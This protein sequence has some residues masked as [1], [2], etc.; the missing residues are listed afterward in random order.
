MSAF[1]DKFY[2]LSVKILDIRDYF[3]QLP[4][5]KQRGNSDE[6]TRFDVTVTY[7]TLLISITM[8]SAS[9]PQTTD[10]LIRD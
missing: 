10:M 1:A 6:L 9:K 8:P 4:L 2:D 3:L 5:F 7:Y